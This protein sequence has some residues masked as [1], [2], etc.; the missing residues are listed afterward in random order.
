MNLIYFLIPESPK[1]LHAMGRFVESRQV[2]NQIASVNGSASE[3]RNFD[4]IRFLGEDEDQNSPNITDRESA[5]F[6]IN[7]NE[8]EAEETENKGL[9]AKA[10]ED[11]AYISANEST[12]GTC[13]EIKIADA[14]EQ[15]T[16]NKI[17]DLW[18]MEK[19]YFFNL[20][21][22]MLTW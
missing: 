15:K 21:I 4:Q 9:L 22:M 16:V 19:P 12:G 17:S 2:L 13:E 10:K 20:L 14:K 6:K 11:G 3:V 8:D 1:Y 7:V 18:D 5:A